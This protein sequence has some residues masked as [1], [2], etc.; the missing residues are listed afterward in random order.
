MEDLVKATNCVDRF[1]SIDSSKERIEYIQYCKG[2]L[3]PS[4]YHIFTMS[5]LRA[6]ILYIN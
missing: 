2:Y 5:I 1:N 3:S 4:A 6:F